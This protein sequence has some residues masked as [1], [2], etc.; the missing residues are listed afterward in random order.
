MVYVGIFIIICPRVIA[1]LDRI[2]LNVLYCA[3]INRDK[4]EGKYDQYAGYN[5]DRNPQFMMVL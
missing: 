5:D 4:R 2:L 3:K 1:D